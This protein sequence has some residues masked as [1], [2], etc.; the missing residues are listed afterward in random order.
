MTSSIEPK[1]LNLLQ[2]NFSFYLY[3]D[4]DEI[5]KIDTR[6]IQIEKD[7]LQYDL[8][9]K[10]SLQL[11][12]ADPAKCIRVL[13][14]YR[15]LRVTA[16]MLKKNPNVVETI[17]RLRRYVG[18]MKDWNFTDEQRVEFDEKAQKVRK[19]SDMIYNNFKVSNVI[20]FL[21]NFV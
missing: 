9:I 14:N 20:I 5:T 15:H 16:L 4:D 12:S 11:S 13:E 3:L 10:S 17:K 19:L 2:I 8:D 6:L 18:N 21:L 1:I 7:I